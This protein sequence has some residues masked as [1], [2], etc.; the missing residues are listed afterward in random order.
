MAQSIPD[1]FNVSA[2][3]RARARFDG[4]VATTR[5]A[6][7]EALLAEGEAIVHLT[8][9]FSYSPLGPA[10]AVGQLRASVPQTC[11]RCLQPMVL[12]IDQGFRVALIDSEKALKK[13]PD[14][15]DWLQLDENGRLDL[16]QLVEDELILALP[17]YP[18][19]PEG[20][21]AGPV[22]EVLSDLNGDPEQ[23]EMRRPFSGLDALIKGNKPKPD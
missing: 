22:A 11:Q 10:Q 9:Q 18:W 16:V 15:Q 23:T 7:F 2:L 5:L 12:E 17:Q 20:E 8:V 1:S 21:C 14:D 3:A 6:R 4:D 19:H 13:L